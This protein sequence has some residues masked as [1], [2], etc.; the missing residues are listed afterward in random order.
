MMLEK[1]S[2]IARKTKKNTV[3]EM[4]IRPLILNARID[5]CIIE[6]ETSLKGEAS[7]SPFLLAGELAAMAGCAFHGRILR[8]ELLTTEEGAARP[9]STLFM[10]DPGKKA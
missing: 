7:L 3:K 2:Y 8:R 4:D 6:V 5:D 9:L 1:T 10:C